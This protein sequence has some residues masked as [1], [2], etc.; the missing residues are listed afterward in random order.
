MPSELTHEQALSMLRSQAARIAELEA[1]LKRKD[2][3][4]EEM[5]EQIE[6]MATRMDKLHDDYDIARGL[7]PPG[8]EEA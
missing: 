4:I 8:Y 1:L 2:E 6:E 7:T 5:E 3:E